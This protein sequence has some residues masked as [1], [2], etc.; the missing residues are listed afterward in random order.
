MALGAV[1]VVLLLAAWG[2]SL[3]VLVAALLGVCAV[4]G[5]GMW[6]LHRRSEAA[7]RGELEAWMARRRTEGGR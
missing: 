1:T 2:A 6:R 5:L 4:M 7:W 3:S